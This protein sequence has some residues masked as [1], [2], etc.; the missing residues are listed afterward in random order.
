[1]QEEGLIKRSANRTK[2]Q[3]V[4][5]PDALF[6][7]FY[8]PKINSTSPRS[9]DHYIWLACSS[10]AKAVREF[11]CSIMLYFNITID[12]S[13]KIELPHCL[14][15]SSKCSAI[16]SQEEN[17]EILSTLAKN[18]E[19]AERHLQDTIDR[20]NTS[21]NAWCKRNTPIQKL[22]ETALTAWVVY[23][24]LKQNRQEDNALMFYT[25]IDF[26]LKHTDTDM[27]QDR[28][29][30]LISAGHY[31]TKYFVQTKVNGLLNVA[32]IIMVSPEFEKSHPASFPLYKG[33]DAHQAYSDFIR[34]YNGYVYEDN[35]QELIQQQ[36]QV[37]DPRAI[38]V[39]NFYKNYY[40]DVKHVYKHLFYWGNYHKKHPHENFTILN[41]TYNT[42]D[43]RNRNLHVT[44]KKYVE[45]LT[46]IKERCKV[47]EYLFFIRDLNF[48]IYRLN[49][50]IEETAS[51]Y[52]ETPDSI[53]KLIET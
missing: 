50:A 27:Q 36:Q 20:N 46:E 23:H 53:K 21:M 18:L 48:L 10:Y 43:L 37:T 17:M 1:M 25:I 39:I 16:K 51:I 47:E 32:D 41:D 4:K 15:A 28:N 38:D 2:P 12:Q 42:A 34:L 14:K 33:Q 26:K 22:R 29:I 13:E 24:N 11:Y 45:M 40:A 49:Q 5:L 6:N 7:D 19:N 9:K 31:K 44:A 52:A 8:Q 30:A 35:E 3:A